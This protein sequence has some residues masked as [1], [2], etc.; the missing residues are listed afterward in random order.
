M[1]S[2]CDVLRIYA[3]STM[4]RITRLMNRG[5]NSAEVEEASAA[6][7]VM[8]SVNAVIVEPVAGSP[9]QGELFPF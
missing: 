9:E 2:S 7:S 5:R 4:S 6:D 1:V 8:V 3:V